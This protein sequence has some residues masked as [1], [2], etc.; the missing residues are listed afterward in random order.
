MNP[1]LL[2]AVMLAAM[3]GGDP[4]VRKDT[5]VADENEDFHA[6]LKRCKQ[7][8]DHPF[9]LCVTG[10]RLIELAAEAINNP[11]AGIYKKQ[12]GLLTKLEAFQDWPERYEYIIGLGRSLP[13]MPEA[14]KTPERLI[15]GCQS[16]VWLD[17]AHED[18]RIRYAADSDSAIT[19]GMIALFV[20][21]LDGETPAAVRTADMSF[22]DRTRLREHLTPSRANAINLMV[23]RMKQL[24]AAPPC[25]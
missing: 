19:K 2:Q 8:A 1:K 15:R 25:S 21:V 5:P 11:P 18:G 4:P 7:C 16:Q 13:Q 12:E 9:A 10:E 24:A 3:F 6:H 17:A 14:L 22:I 23:T 20:Q